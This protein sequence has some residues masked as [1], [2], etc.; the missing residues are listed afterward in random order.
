VL[1]K[2]V[3]NWVGRADDSRVTPSKTPP[4]GEVIREVGLYLGSHWLGKMDR[5]F[6]NGRV[7]LQGRFC[8]PFG[9]TE[10]DNAFGAEF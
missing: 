8:W 4:R 1:M 10:W 7:V 9:Q 2:P 6:A 5:V 3:S